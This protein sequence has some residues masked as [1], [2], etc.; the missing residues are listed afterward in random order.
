[1]LAA[2][3]A[4][5]AAVVRRRGL[6]LLRG[7]AWFDRVVVVAGVSAW[8]L[9]PPSSS[10]SSSC[11]LSPG[12]ACSTQ[13]VSYTRIEQRRYFS[14]DIHNT[15]TFITHKFHVNP[16]SALQ[17][18][19]PHYPV[20]IVVKTGDLESIEVD[21]DIR[22]A[23]G[24]ISIEKVVE[25]TV[26]I[27]NKCLDDVGE[28][29]IIELGQIRGAK[30]SIDTDAGDITTGHIAAET[31]IICHRGDIKVQKLISNSLSLNASGRIDINVLYADE[32]F[33]K[34]TGD[35]RVG[36]AKLGSDSNMAE[37]TTHVG[38]IS[39]DGLDGYAKGARRVDVHSNSHFSVINLSVPHIP[40]VIEAAF[41]TVGALSIEESTLHEIVA[42]QVPHE[43][44]LFVIEA[45]IRPTDAEAKAEAHVLKL[46]VLAEGSHATVT[47]NRR[48]WKEAMES[49][50]QRGG[51]GVKALSSDQAKPT[52]R[53]VSWNSL[54]REMR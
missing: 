29:G 50:M 32:C 42:Q 47:V 20:D 44:H 48:S 13:G 38:D 16:P 54:W 31:R 7:P 18:I 26:N 33:I 8:P 12:L 41:P 40:V 9:Q 14:G 11:L 3:A 27:I 46:N 30:L 52:K 21:V 49:R 39:I 17:L 53:Y 43:H 6:R 37:L 23:G 45:R 22:N 1:M 28:R 10:S 24:N 5:A 25:G 36:T 4:A 35:I 34:S 51:G 19:S 2:G 15:S